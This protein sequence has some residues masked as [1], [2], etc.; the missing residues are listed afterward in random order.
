MRIQEEHDRRKRE[1]ST[2]DRLPRALEELHGMLKQCVETYRANFGEDSASLLLMPTRI[3]IT[4]RE[5][6]GEQWQTVSKVE[7]LTVPELPGFRVER[8]EYS[9]ALEVGILPNDKLYY[10]DREQDKYL[11]LEELTKRILDRA[12]FPKLKE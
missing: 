4:M 5:Q 7:V 6:Q 3:K 10:R 2:L 1:A 8:G 11:T 9:L 12:F